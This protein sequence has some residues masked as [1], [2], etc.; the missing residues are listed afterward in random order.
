MG[1]S[2]NLL[3]SVVHLTLCITDLLFIVIVL[4]IVHDR[5]QIHWMEPILM[6]V[7]PLMSVVLNWFHPLVL[8][9]TGKSYTERALLFLMITCLLVLRF[10]I[11]SIFG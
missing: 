8:R 11:V 2:E 4:K 5:R 6:A 7:R 10:L 9:V 1:L 3:I